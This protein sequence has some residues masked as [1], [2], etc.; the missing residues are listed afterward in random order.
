MFNILK[1]YFVT[2]FRP[3]RKQEDETSDAMKQIEKE[4]NDISNQDDITLSE[5]A[6]LEELEEKNVNG[7]MVLDLGM[8]GIL[9]M[10]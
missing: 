2:V 7:K 4:S 8:S 3:K 9:V 10:L 5:E 6:A 1:S